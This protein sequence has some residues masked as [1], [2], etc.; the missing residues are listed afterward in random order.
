MELAS[1]QLN[2]FLY[3]SIWVCIYAKT[4]PRSREELVSSHL[5]SDNETKE[6]GVQEYL[7][8]PLQPH[9]KPN[10]HSS[11]TDPRSTQ[12][13][14]RKLLS[15]PPLPSSDCSP[16]KGYARHRLANEVL[17]TLFLKHSTD[18]CSPCCHP[19]ITAL[20]ESSTGLLTLLG[21]TCRAQRPIFL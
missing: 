8:F 9:W 12:T 2:Y 11:T 18:V 17:L 13:S 4:D 3:T 6:T 19:E 15:Q 14:R 1:S 7:P 21:L 5:V 16:C 10:T 20:F